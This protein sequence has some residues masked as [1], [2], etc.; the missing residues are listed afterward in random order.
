MGNNL[1]TGSIPK[2]FLNM[3]KLRSFGCSNR[4]GFCVPGTRAF[5][6][7]IEGLESFDGQWCNQFDS[8]VLQSLYKATDG[9]DWRESDGWLGGPVLGEW[10]GVGVDTL[11]R[12]T[13]IDLESNDLAGQVP[14]NLGYLS[15]LMELRIGGNSA[16][17]GRLPVSLAGL[18]LST[19]HYAGTYLCYPADESFGEWLKGVA[20]H[21]GTGVLCAPLSDREILADVYREAGG[22]SW[23]K[24]ENWLTDSPLGEWTG[25]DTDGSGSVV[26]LDL[27][28]RSLSGGI[29]PDLGDLE[30][31]KSLNL[32]WN[33]LS[34]P[35]PPKL[36]NLVILEEL[37]L[38]GNDLS[39]PI[40]PRTR[41]SREPGVAL[42]HQ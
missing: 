41:E 27:S 1:L 37:R 10:H 23:T 11:G 20:S 2:E 38:S 42:A 35:I 8:T 22:P 5:S 9:P 13:A 4:H 18:T 21:E 28:Y 15:E 30:N 19:L 24:S 34:G 3:L 25:V 39:G 32:S 36:G 17:S 29:P 33:D 12:V 7:W 14:S 26:G 6:D 31:L 16:L 40:P